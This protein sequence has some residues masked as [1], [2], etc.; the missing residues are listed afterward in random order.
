MLGWKNSPDRWHNRQPLCA[1][2]GHTHGGSDE[3]TDSQ[4]SLA[5]EHSSV[6]GLL[7]KLTA[8]SDA[9]ANNYTFEVMTEREHWS[10]EG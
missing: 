7:M 10:P 5:G 1:A 8:D 3:V 4:I 2:H 9:K 6:H